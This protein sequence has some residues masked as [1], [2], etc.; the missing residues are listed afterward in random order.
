MAYEGL[1][2]FNEHEKAVEDLYFN[3]EEE[4]LLRKL[5][6]K[7]RKQSEQADQHAAVGEQAAEQS[8]LRAI[9]GKYKVSDA[10]FEALLRWKH[11]QY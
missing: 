11:T 10:D 1:K 7:V 6:T 3:K 2:G 5:L 9:V 8:A 4:K